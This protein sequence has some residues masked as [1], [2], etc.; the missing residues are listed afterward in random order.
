MLISGV[1]VAETRG[2]LIRVMMMIMIAVSLRRWRR[3]CVPLRLLHHQRRARVHV[4]VNRVS[5]RVATDGRRRGCSGYLFAIRLLVKA[6]QGRLRLRWH[7]ISEL[8]VDLLVVVLVGHDVVVVER[9][10]V[11]LGERGVVGVLEGRKRVLLLHQLRDGI[12]MDF[13]PR[14]SCAAAMSSGRTC[15]AV[16]V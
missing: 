6:V 5:R 9:L 7:K 12:L 8:S 15:T 1:R 13:P 11:V 14:A 2:R 16:S 4:V 10:Q 3:R